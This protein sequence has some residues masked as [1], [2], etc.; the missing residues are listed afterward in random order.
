[1]TEYRIVETKVDYFYNLQKKVS[2]LGFTFW[3]TIMKEERI[4]TCE[5]KMEREK[6]KILKEREGYRVVKTYIIE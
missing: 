1:M 3:K 4:S 2:I 5:W 6:R